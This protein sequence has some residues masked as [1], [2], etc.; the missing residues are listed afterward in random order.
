MPFP[1]DGIEL[2]SKGSAASH[3]RLRFKRNPKRY[4]RRAHRCYRFSFTG[5]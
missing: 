5:I 4:S 2:Y 1:P 3:L